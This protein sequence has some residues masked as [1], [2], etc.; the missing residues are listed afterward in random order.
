MQ[1]DLRVDLIKSYNIEKPVS[2]MIANLEI[3]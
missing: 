3:E 1:E 2:E